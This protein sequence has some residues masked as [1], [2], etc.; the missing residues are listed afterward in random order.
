MYLFFFELQYFKICEFRFVMI[1]KI[2]NAK[3][4]IFTKHKRVI[5][6]PNQKYFNQFINYEGILQKS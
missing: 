3:D 4:I 2:R 5:L 1:S 6:I